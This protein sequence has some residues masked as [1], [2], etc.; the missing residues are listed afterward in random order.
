MCQLFVDD[1]SIYKISKPLLNFCNGRTNGWTDRQAQ[2]NYA[3]STFSKSGHL[4]SMYNQQASSST[5]KNPTLETST[6]H[7]RQAPHATDKH[8]P[9]QT[10]NSYYRQAP[11]TRDKPQTLQ[12]STT[13][14][15]QAPNTTHKHHKLHV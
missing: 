9:Q 1:K 10:N 12:T 11:D 13:H 4:N 6:E 5:Y 14:Y 8:Q 3:P 15:K 2:S 7:Y